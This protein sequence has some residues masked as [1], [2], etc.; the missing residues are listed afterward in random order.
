[1]SEVLVDPEY[2]LSHG[3]NLSSQAACELCEA[4]WANADDLYFIEK[5]HHRQMF[6]VILAKEIPECNCGDDNGYTRQTWVQV[7]A[8]C[9]FVLI[10]DNVIDLT[11]ERFEALYFGIRG[12]RPKVSV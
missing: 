11:V 2:L 7:D 9:G 3:F 4:P 10:P 12:K 1:M 8:G 6:V 5:E